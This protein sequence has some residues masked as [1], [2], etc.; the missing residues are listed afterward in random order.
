MSSKTVGNAP[1]TKGRT[2]RTIGIPTKTYE[3]LT[4]LAKSEGRSTSFFALEI[5]SREIETRLNRAQ[6]G[7]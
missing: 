5:L 6:T 1:R 2:W 3:A 7:S 4:R